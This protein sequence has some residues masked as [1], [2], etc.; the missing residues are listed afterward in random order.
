METKTNPNPAEGTLT[1][2]VC[3]DEP[4]LQKSVVDQLTGEFKVF[5]GLFVEDI[6]LK[7]RAQQF[8]VIIIFENFNGTDIEANQVLAEAKNLPAPQR[9]R[10]YFVLLGPNMIT[11]NELQAFEHSVD[12]VFCVSDLANFRPVLRRGIARHKEFYAIF[13]ETLKMAG[14]A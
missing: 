3:V 14:A 1:A 10:Q 7:F 8:D 6:S 5:T 12:M 11:N 13:N 2:L 4:H 9:R